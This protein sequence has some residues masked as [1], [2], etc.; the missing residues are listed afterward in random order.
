MTFR[1]VPQRGEGSEQAPPP[2]GGGIYFC[3][4]RFCPRD[5]CYNRHTLPHKR[6]SKHQQP[7]WQL[8]FR[9]PSRLL[10]LNCI[11]GLVEGGGIHMQPCPTLMA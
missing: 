7:L 1:T 10:P 8:L 5:P 6:F 4:H 11:P 2:Y 3:P 9:T